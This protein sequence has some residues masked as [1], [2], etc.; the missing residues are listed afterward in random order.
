M[1]ELK[2]MVPLSGEKLTDTPAT[3]GEINRLTSGREGSEG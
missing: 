2:D 3:E 1:S